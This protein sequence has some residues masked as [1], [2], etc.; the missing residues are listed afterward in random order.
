MLKEL[1]E[2]FTKVVASPMNDKILKNR[3]S[4]FSIGQLNQSD[5]KVEVDSIV[6]RVCSI[7]GV[8]LPRTELIADVIAKEFMSLLLDFGYEDLTVD[9]IILAFQ[10]N[11]VGVRYPSGFDIDSIPFTGVTFNISFAAKVLGNYMQVRKI[12]DG[13]FRNYLEGAQ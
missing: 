11:T 1:A 3:L 9:E 4:G 13:M 8:E 6:V 10:F 12:M 2:K 5:L 7:Y